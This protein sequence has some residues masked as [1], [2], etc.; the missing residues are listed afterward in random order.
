MS[1]QTKTEVPPFSAE[2]VEAVSHLL[3]GAGGLS[4]NEIGGI[5]GAI[6]VADPTPHL[7]SWKRLFNA[8]VAFQNRHQLGNAVIVFISRAMDPGRYNE[9]ALLFE[10]RRIG[11]NQILGFS[12]FLV[13]GDGKVVRCDPT[14]AVDES[15]ITANQFLSQLMTRGAHDEVY[16]CCTPEILAR[17][18]YYAVF[19]AM[20]GITHK[21]RALSGLTGD[22][23]SL[24]ERAFALDKAGQ[25]LVAI[26]GLETDGL[27][28]EQRAFLSLLVGLFG[29]AR[30]PVAY[31]AKLDWDMSEVDALDVMSLVS[32]VHRKLDLAATI[33]STV[34]A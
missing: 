15:V 31:H 10:E 4:P 6:G 29:T 32:L 5:L 30:N 17:G 23:A 12:G 20:K 24:M 2:H 34:G 26:N 8:L 33:Q 13:R 18:Y 9:H 22:G 27:R 21:V 28:A 14:K 11:L 1:L 16:Q 7:K 3:G 19:E 25:P